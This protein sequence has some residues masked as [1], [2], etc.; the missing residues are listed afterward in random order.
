MAPVRQQRARQVVASASAHATPAS[1]GSACEWTG[2]TALF[3][4]LP[5]VPCFMICSKAL[6]GINFMKQNHNFIKFEEVN[7]FGL[8]SLL[9]H[10][11][12]NCTF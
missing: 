7:H 11:Y 8:N 2:T 4:S 10:N 9:F 5:C 1:Y 3:H 12:L 6:C